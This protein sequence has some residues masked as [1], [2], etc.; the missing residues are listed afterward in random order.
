MKRDIKTTLTSAQYYRKLGDEILTLHTG[1]T[2][3]WSEEYRKSL[4]E[5]HY[6]YADK[7]EKEEAEQLVK[8]KK[9]SYRKG[10]N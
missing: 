10:K 1:T 4:R 3:D 6:K 2:K 8:F 7:V 9:R 5:Q